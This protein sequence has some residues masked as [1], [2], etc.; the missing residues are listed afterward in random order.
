MADHVGG[1]HGPEV[2]MTSGCHRPLENVWCLS[3]L[4]TY[5]LHENA[6]IIVLVLSLTLDDQCK[7]V[8]C[9]M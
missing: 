8:I 4:M 5:Q 1:K 6:F 3:S 9:S 7:A 2:N